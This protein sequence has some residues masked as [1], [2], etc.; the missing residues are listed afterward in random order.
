MLQTDWH[1]QLVEL[2]LDRPPANAFDMALVGA[3][4]AAIASLPGAG[5]RALVIS[6]SPGLFSGG[7][8]VPALLALD[9]DGIRAFWSAYFGLLRDVAGCPVPVL[10]ALTGHSPA[11]GAVL[12][13][14]CDYRIGAAGDFRI[15]FNEV[16]VGL[17]IPAAILGVMRATLGYRAARLLT[18]SGELVDMQRALELGLLDELVA[19]PDVVPVALA[20]AAELVARPPRAMNLTRL[21]LKRPILN[22]LDAAGDV[23]LATDYWFSEETQAAMRELASRLT[24]D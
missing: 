6:G 1:G 22:L 4:R 18:V 9:R 20:R 23:E 8:D 3:L 11:G 14:H 10:A 5:A 24:G 17:P 16:E 12:A 7:L 2:R 15:G 21:E 19:P 13:L